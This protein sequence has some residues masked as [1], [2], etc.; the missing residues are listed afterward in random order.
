LQGLR[1]HRDLVVR[2][3]NQARLDSEVWLELTVTLVAPGH[4]VDEVTAASRA[5][6]VQQGNVVARVLVEV[7]E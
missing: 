3:V 4:K 7:L 5:R 2:L 1:V 6:W